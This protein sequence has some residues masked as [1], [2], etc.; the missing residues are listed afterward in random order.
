MCSTRDTAWREVQHHPLL[1]NSV[2]PQFVLLTVR[3]I[4]QILPITQRQP[5]RDDGPDVDARIARAF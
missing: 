2:L 1:A 4:P 3:P 5:A